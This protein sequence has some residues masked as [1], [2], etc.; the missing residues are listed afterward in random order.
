MPD[1]PREHI[2]AVAR[3][4]MDRYSC[5]REVDTQGAVYCG[6]HMYGWLSNGLCPHA[7]AAADAILLSTDPAIL[8]ALTD[9]LVRAG[10]LRKEVSEYC[11]CGHYLTYHSG[12]GCWF[13]TTFTQRCICTLMRPQN[14]RLVTGWREGT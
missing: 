13:T 4:V 3:A 7:E 12:D 10:R 14:H 6:R 8:D 11:T 1:I 2:E 5:Q 9:A